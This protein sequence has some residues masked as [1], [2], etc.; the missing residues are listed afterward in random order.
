MI[1]HNI[2]KLLDEAQEELSVIEENKNK[3]KR[4]SKKFLFVFRPS[5]WRTIKK[6][7]KQLKKVKCLMSIIK[8]CICRH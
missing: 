8:K 5:Y 2:K 7:V 3:I 1:N 4:I 6:Q